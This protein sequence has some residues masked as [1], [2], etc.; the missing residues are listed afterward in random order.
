MK[1]LMK[2]AS[3][4]VAASLALGT[5]SGCGTKKNANGKIQISIGNWADEKTNKTDYDT[6]MG[7][8]ERFEAKYPQYEIVPDTYIPATDTFTMK[9][10]AHQLPNLYKVH[11]TE[12]QGIIKNKYA[13]DI[14]DKLQKEGWLQYMN[15]DVREI[16][17]DDEGKVYGIPTQVYA[18]GLMINKKLFR[19]AGLVNADG[20]IMIPRT[21]EEME[22]YAK[23]IKEKTGK[24]G[25]VTPTIQNGG[26]WKIM[27]M[28][29]SNGV[30]FM[31][32]GEDGKYIATFDTP[33]M[34]KTL[35]YLSDLKWKD[36]A[37]PDDSNIGIEDSNKLFATNQAAM[38]FNGAD[39]VEMNVR[40]FG[41]NL[42]DI[43]M[44][45]MPRG[46]EGAFSQMGGYTI[47]ISSDTTDEQL[48]GIIEWVKFTGEA[49]PVEFTDE[50][51]A[52]YEDNIKNNVAEN[53]IVFPRDTFDIWNNEEIN[54]KKN[55]IRE[56]YSNVDFANYED[57]FAFNGISIKPEEPQCCQELY[58]VLDGVI[59]DVITDKNADIA[60]IIKTANNDFQLN[61]L[62]KQ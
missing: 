19:D 20:S 61:H 53:R 37:L 28:A 3:V 36:N 58:A 1:K 47:M 26:G 22:E 13:R 49:N 12:P 50:Q 43:M 31:K 56:K 5:F 6:M 54:N 14:T 35:Q 41:A 11:F 45:G 7:I 59:Q 9:A 29:W 34:Q 8:K 48:D 27:S 24:A 16:L 25:Y 46:P 42:D 60:S 32:E 18:L 51:A 55:A 38:M 57:Y 23:T 30:E 33:E 21:Y 44:V 39:A 4:V 2:I 52:E 15:E 40:S 62:D 10:T 17:S